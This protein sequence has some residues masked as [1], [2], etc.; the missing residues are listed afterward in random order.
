MKK[1]KSKKLKT[2]EGKR[3]EKKS[4]PKFREYKTFRL[5]KPT[6]ELRGDI[7]SKK[8]RYSAGKDVYMYTY[9]LGLNASVTAVLV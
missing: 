2:S 6:T 9:R 1:R 8:E 7:H 3:D 4:W 5:M